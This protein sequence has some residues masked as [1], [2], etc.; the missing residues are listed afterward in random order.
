MLEP[1]EDR[2]VLNVTVTG[3]ATNTITFTSDSASDNLS[4]QTNTSGVLEY[5]DS[6]QTPPTTTSPTFTVGSGTSI[7]V[8]E[9]GGTLNLQNLDTQGGS[10]EVD[11]DVTLTGSLNTEGGAVNLYGGI[12][13]VNAN[14]TTGGGALTIENKGNGNQQGDTI[15]VNS[16]QSSAFFSGSSGTLTAG[17]E[18]F[19]I[20]S[21][22]GTGNQATMTVAPPSGTTDTL[23][24][25]E[26]VTYAGSASGL[27]AGSTYYVQVPDSNSPTSIQLYQQV[28]ISTSSTTGKA[29]AITL[30]A[31]TITLDPC[32]QLLAKG[33]AND[34]I[35]TLTADYERDD[36]S[37]A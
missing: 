31:P 33:S 5:T 21:S 30:D 7:I 10:F 25:G 26:Q 1:L 15:T 27:T 6:S 11:N 37:K 20:Q 34:G 24:E 35:I 29:G 13:T 9:S 32:T 19:T 17:K 22:T 18:S 14:L 12:V 2:I 3:A 8:S 28:V 16:T 36:L 23:T 4:L